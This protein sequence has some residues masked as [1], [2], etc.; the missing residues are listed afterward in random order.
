MSFMNMTTADMDQVEAQALTT[1]KSIKAYFHQIKIDKLQQL[2]DSETNGSRNQIVEQE[3][4]QQE[5]DSDEYDTVDDDDD[6]DDDEEDDARTID[7]SVDMFNTLEPIEK[8]IVRSV[9]N[10]IG[11]EEEDDSFYPS[12]A[13]RETGELL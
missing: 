12:S 3:Q 5:Q 1:A 9:L 10:D 2:H 11:E 6:D 8:E 7:T 4:E 13:Y